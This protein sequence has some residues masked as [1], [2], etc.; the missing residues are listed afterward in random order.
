LCIVY[1]P[2]VCIHALKRGRKMQRQIPTRE[3]VESY[4]SDRRNW[5][6]WKDNPSAGTINLITPKKRIDAARLVKTGEA[7]SLSNPLPVESS[8]ANVRPVDFYLKKLDWIDDGGGVLDYI[9][10]FQHG[11]TVTHLDALCHVW[12]RHG[13]WEGKNPDEI[14][15]FDGA[16]FGGIEAW[17]N[18]ILTRGVLIDVPKFRGV[19]YVDIDHPVHG[20]ELEDI[21]VAQN[22]Q[23]QPGDALLVYCGKEAYERENGPYGGDNENSKGYPGL[24]ASCLPFIR[25]NDISV[26]L[27]DM[28]DAYPNEYDL[29]W[30]IHGAIHSYGLAIV[31]GARLD[32]LAKLCVDNNLYQF[33]LTVN[34]LIVNGGTGSPVNP[35]AVF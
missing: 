14:L 25:D 29:A 24:H 1:R 26:L 17:Q 13:M 10:L 9:G 28:E 33:M 23:L 2:S 27:W 34:P 3:Q 22:V 11:L 6:R 31:D 5:G 12:D 35:V 20:W 16:K 7:V 18:G 4:L 32:R 30:T 21:V 19:D 15:T 8:T